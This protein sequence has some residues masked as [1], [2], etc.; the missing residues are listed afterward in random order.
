MLDGLDPDR[1]IIDIERTCRLAGSRTN[2][3]CE[4]WKI[5]GRVQDIECLLPFLLVNQIIPVRNDV[6][7]WTASHA[8]RDATI[9]AAGA[10][11]ARFVVGKP[12]YEFTI[13]LYALALVLSS[14]D[15]ALVLHETS[16]LSH[17]SLLSCFSAVQG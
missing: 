4:L 7:Y 5:I 14:L 3:S 2:T 9:H 11:Y 1:I 15:K 12:E 6:V 10:L 16:Y 8:E 17:Q 13:V